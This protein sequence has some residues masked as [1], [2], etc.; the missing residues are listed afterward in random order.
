MSRQQLPGN[1]PPSPQPSAA[2][3]QEQCASPRLLTV[4]VNAQRPELQPRAPDANRSA[5]AASSQ[6]ADAALPHA[7]QL[8]QQRVCLYSCRQPGRPTLW[9][10]EADD[11]AAAAAAA[12]STPAA[13]CRCSLLRWGQAA[14]VGCK[15]ACHPSDVAHRRRHTCGKG[16]QQAAGSASAVPRHPVVGNSKQMAT[17]DKG[18]E[19]AG[20]GECLAKGCGLIGQDGVV[21]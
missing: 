16:A 18:R 17:P 20:P 1:Q 12:A 9:H 19:M 11:E 8:E 13:A 10:E 2:C 7:R 21:A 3:R 4:G 6:N 15:S 5:A 14:P